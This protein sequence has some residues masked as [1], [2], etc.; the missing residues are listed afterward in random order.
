MEEKLELHLPSMIDQLKMWHPVEGG[1]MAAVVVV[2][3]AAEEVVVDMAAHLH[4][5]VI[6]MVD[7]L[8]EENV[9]EN[10]P[11]LGQDP[12]QDPVAEEV[13]P[14]HQNTLH[15]KG[16][17]PQE[18]DRHPPEEDRHPQEKDHHPQEKDHHLLEE[19]RLL[20]AEDPHLHK[21]LYHLC[22]GLYHLADTNL[23]LKAGLQAVLQKAE[24]QAQAR[25][26]LD[27]CHVTDI[28]DH[29]DY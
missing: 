1:L 12:D 13:D 27:W 7:A 29:I 25:N 5:G 21:G 4:E 15:E 14:D 18:K 11:I 28:A 20:H 10:D 16:L 24:V 2:E 22:E 19:G 26:V 8:I 23:S 9:T 17:H 3:A 6:G